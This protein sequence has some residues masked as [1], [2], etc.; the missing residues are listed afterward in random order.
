MERTPAMAGVPMD[1]A[2]GLIGT[3][4]ELKSHLAVDHNEDDTYLS[5]LLLSSLRAVG[6]YTQWPMT[7]GTYAVT[8]R[9]PWRRLSR[10][11]SYPRRRLLLP[12]PVDA[13]GAVTAY[14]VSGA[15]LVA[16]D[17][18]AVRVQVSPRWP[19]DAWIELPEDFNYDDSGN[20]GELLLRYQ[21]GWGAIYTD[22]DA[23]WPRELAHTIYRVAATLYLYRE[24]TMAGD[25]PLR[26]VMQSTLGPYLPVYL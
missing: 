15:T 24:A 7:T 2:T 25:Y 26:R 14:T 17:A 9:W 21:A 11:P 4:A 6:D 18:L 1:G 23:P 20:R 13:S 22:A 10:T 12:G 19:H 16:G 8:A 3:I 5:A